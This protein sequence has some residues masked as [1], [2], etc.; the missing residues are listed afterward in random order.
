MVFLI[1][2]VLGLALAYGF[3][4]DDGPVLFH[5]PPATLIVVLAWPFVIYHLFP[6]HVAAITKWRG[7]KL[8]NRSK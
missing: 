7:E 4:D 3:E 1:Y 5:N 8:R 2:L 6:N